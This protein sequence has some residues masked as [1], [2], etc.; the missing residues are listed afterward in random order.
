MANN[1]T[2]FSFY[3]T[4][5]D[6]YFDVKIRRLKKDFG[7]SG[8]AVHDYILCEIYRNNGCFIAWDESTAFN[9]ADYF[10]L[11][12]SLVKEIVSYCCVVGLFDKEL[13]TNG[14]VLSSKSIQGMYVD[15]CIR[16]KRNLIIIPEEYN[17]LTEEYRIILEEYAKK[18]EQCHIVYNSIVKKSKEKKKEEISEVAKATSLSNCKQPDTSCPSNNPHVSIDFEKLICWF[19]ETTKGVFGVIRIPLSD[20]RKKLLRARISEHGKKSFTKVVE[21]ALKIDLLRGKNRAGLAASIDWLIK[22]TNY[23]KVLS[24]NFA[25]TEDEVIRSISDELF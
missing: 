3:R 11:K 24:G 2:G 20:K 21:N 9:V 8:L 10:G 15:M 14:G 12:E 5:T 23:E 17:I 7:C 25:D 16:A 4:D 13:L 18:T 22:P 19:N 6:R 1:K